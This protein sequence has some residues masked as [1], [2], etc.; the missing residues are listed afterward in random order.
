MA[1]NT[2]LGFVLLVGVANNNDDSAD[3]ADDGVIIDNCVDVGMS[4]I[5][6]VDTNERLRA[7]TFP[8]NAFVAFA[9]A[10]NPFF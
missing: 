3:N 4:V 5:W 9:S 6:V 7:T 2:V 1:G 8:M 10:D